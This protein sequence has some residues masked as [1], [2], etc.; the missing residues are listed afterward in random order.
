[1]STWKG[2]PFPHLVF[3]FKIEAEAPFSPI[4]HLVKHGDALGNA[5]WRQWGHGK[6]KS[7]SPLKIWV[8]PGANPRAGFV[9]VEEQ[10]GE[11]PGKDLARGFRA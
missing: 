1:M 3:V 9:Q 10:E 7:S 2:L 8:T 6:G 5:P 11:L 4:L